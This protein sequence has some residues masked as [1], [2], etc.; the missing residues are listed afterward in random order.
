MPAL[1]DKYVGEVVP[2][3]K[4][5]L[6]ITNRLRVP[7]LA[8]VVVNMGIGIA[9][10]DAFKNC[11]DDLAMVT[12]QKPLVTKARKSISNFKVREGMNIGAKV[13]LRGDRMYEFLDRLINVALPRIRDFRGL[14]PA[15][16]DGHGNYTFGVL[17]QTIFPEIDPNN[18]KVNQGMDI[19]IGT[20]T[21]N[22]SEARE[23]LKL[24]GM[25][26]SGG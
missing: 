15:S 8:K 5:Q 21:E 12:G 4:K 3:L 13:T 26:F 24:L 19:T 9:E 14:A 7:R 16:F 11:T 20:S 23:L 25:P 22:D 18:V 1:K 2:L 6:G 10:K 17:E